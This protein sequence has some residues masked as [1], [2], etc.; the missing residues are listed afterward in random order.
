M[1]IAKLGLTGAMAGML[2]VGPAALAQD[3]EIVIGSA[4][5]LTGVQ[6]PLDTPGFL[7]AQ[8]AVKV[9]NDN[10]GLLGKPVRLINVD[11]KSDPVTVGSAAVE[12][13]DQGADLIIA[14]C[15]FD[16]GGPASREGVKSASVG[17]KP[18]S[19][20]PAPVSATSS[21]CRPAS[22]AASIAAW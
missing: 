12:L 7:G 22:L 4:L 11:G 1:S 3:D 20:L 18:A 17:R 6:A 21:A 19:V 15:D 10:G 2:F 8:V 9:L 13:I 16:F 5:C 14:P